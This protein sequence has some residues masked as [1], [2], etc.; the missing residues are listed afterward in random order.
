MRRAARHAIR[1]SDSSRTP[2]FTIVARADA[3]VRHR[4]HDRHVQ[5]RQR[6][7][8]AAAAVSRVRPA[9]ARAR[10]RAAVRPVFGRA[11]ELPRLARSRARRSSASSRYTNGT[12]HFVGPDGPRADAERLGVVGHLRTGP[13]RSRRSAAAFSAD[14]DA[15]GKNAVIVLS[16]RH[17]AAAVRRGPERGRPCDH[18]Q[19]RAGHD[20][21]RDAGGIL[22]SRA[23]PSTGGRSRF[24]GEGHRAAGTSSR[25]SRG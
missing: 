6:R 13:R 16:H 25:S 8:A 12:R 15:P 24:T 7:P 18:A 1:A 21:R 22:L 11:G 19:R 2:G 14:E 4:R 10:D 3:R 5:R 23:T 20:R 9:R 17:V